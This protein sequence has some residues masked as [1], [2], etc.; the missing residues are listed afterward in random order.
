MKNKKFIIALLI[1]SISIS[2]IIISLF[3]TSYSNKYN[4]II[5]NNSSENIENIGFITEN[6]SSGVSHADNTPIKP[7][8]NI[9]MNIINNSFSLTITDK[10]GTIFTSEPFYIE[11]D[12]K[13][14]NIFNILIEKNSSSN[15]DFILQDYKK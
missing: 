9:K 8:E 13:K 12:S 3:I 4:L 10:N 15:W 1:L 6:S 5:T 14:N 11:I 7:G 2:I